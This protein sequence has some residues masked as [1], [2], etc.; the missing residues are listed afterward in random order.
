MLPQWL[1]MTASEVVAQG[2][3]A[4]ERGDFVYIPGRINR[5]LALLARVL[6]RRVLRA[7]IASRE[8]TFRR[9]D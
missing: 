9:I 1:W 5:A 8:H 4:V 7:L 2:L 3:A 6:P